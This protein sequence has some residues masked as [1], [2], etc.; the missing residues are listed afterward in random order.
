MP[1]RKTPVGPTRKSPP[2]VRAGEISSNGATWL[3]VSETECR[4]VIIVGV[5]EDIPRAL[6]HP[7][8]TAG[9]FE[10]VAALAVDVES[11]DQDSGMSQLAAL[12]DAH[13]AET[14]LVA[15]PVGAGSMRRVADLALLHHCELLAVMPTEVLAGHDPVIVWSGESPLVQLARIPRRR[16]EVQVKR[17]F[18]VVASALGLLVTTPV[19]ALL[20]V[21]IRLESRG[22]V[23]FRH[24][25]IGRDG[26]KFQCLKLRTMGSDAEAVLRADPE[27]YEE[28]R[29]NHY[30]I[31]DDQDPRVTLV[32]R[33]VRRTSLDELP[34]LWN[35]LVGEMSLVGPRP[36]VEEEL[37]HY[38]TSRDLLLSVRPGITGAWAVSGRHGVG[39]PERCDIELAYVRRWTLYSDV[40]ALARTVGAV[41]RPGG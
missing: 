33:F 34:Q 32:G 16:W 1:P 2:R 11:D 36:V 25:R 7:A 29:R 39:Y 12:L 18:D 3:D 6:E 38:G 37:E 27:M 8:A 9:R 14:I 31:P 19:F 28:Y 4:R 20:A 41:V 15:G 26:R 17:A 23:L 13:R 35:V 30:K 40:S 24:E 5:P 21:A 10:V 22:S